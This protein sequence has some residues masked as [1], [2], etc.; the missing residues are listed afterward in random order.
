MLLNRGVLSYFG[1]TLLVFFLLLVS[2]EVPY[3]F[4]FVDS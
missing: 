2:L 1:F 3:E 4:P